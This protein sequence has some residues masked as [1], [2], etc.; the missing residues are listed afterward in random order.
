MEDKNIIELFFK[1]SEDAIRECENK[2]G[3]YCMSISLRI[4]KNIEDARECVNDSL[5]KTW[6]TIPPKRPKI[7]R[8]FL[9]KIT[10]NESINRYNYENALKRGGDEI[11]LV[12]DEL[13][14]CIAGGFNPEDSIE[15]MDL[16]RILNDFLDEISKDQRLIFLERYWNFKTV[17]EISK[18]YMFTESKVK[19]T[20]SRLRKAL[21]LKLKKEGMIIDGQK[22]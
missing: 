10:R 13:E 8:V 21:L 16:S 19:M 18:E 6:N 7:L 14:E 1:R 20:L 2:Y 5:F 4:L 22:N 12:F 11:C 15:I 9:G 17:K 3:R